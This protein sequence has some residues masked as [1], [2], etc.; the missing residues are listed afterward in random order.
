M[1]VFCPAT[2]TN[3]GENVPPLT[4]GRLDPGLVL[5]HLYAGSPTHPRA[6]EGKPTILEFTDRLVNR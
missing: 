5:T 1:P 3:L 4:N 2:I 6:D